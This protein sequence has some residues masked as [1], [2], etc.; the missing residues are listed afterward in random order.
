[1]PVKEY[2]SIN[3]VAQM[4]GLT[5]KTLRNY[6]SARLLDGEKVD[7]NWKFSLQAV[8]K[9][10]KDPFVEASVKI[11]NQIVVKDFLLDEQKKTDSTCLI[12]DKVLS[13]EKALELSQFFCQIVNESEAKV[14]FKMFQKEENVR[15]ILSGPENE[16][17]DIMSAYK[18]T[19]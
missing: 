15:I 12:L 10:L 5:T 13:N 16:I 4:T 8:E 9:M 2:Y 14:Q 1:M 6:I 3:E 11:K 17:M 7:G 19:F 18:K